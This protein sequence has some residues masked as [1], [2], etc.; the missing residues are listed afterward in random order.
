MS[1]PNASSSSALVS[2]TQDVDY[3]KAEGFKRFKAMYNHKNACAACNDT[4][5]AYPQAEDV[6]QA[7]KGPRCS[8]WTFDG[9]SLQDF[10]EMGAIA[11][12]CHLKCLFLAPYYAAQMWH[13]TQ[14]WDKRDDQGPGS[15]VI[16]T[17]HQLVGVVGT[18]LYHSMGNVQMT[19]SCS[20]GAILM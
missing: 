3:T 1:A 19:V 8:Q 9:L 17:C 4:R 6:Y 15:E 12:H 10:I 2:F 11:A 18:G 14:K 16:D 20:C 7:T 13:C 5:G